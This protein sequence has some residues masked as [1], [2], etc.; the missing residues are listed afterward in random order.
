MHV[1]H[2]TLQF[3][4]IFCGI[5]AG[6]PGLE[7]LHAASVYSRFIHARAVVI[8][9]DRSVLPW[10]AAFVG[11]SCVENFFQLS[12]GRF[13]SR[14]ALA[15][16]RHGCRDGIVRAPGAVGEFVEVVARISLAIEIGDVDAVQGCGFEQDR[17]D[18]SDERTART[19]ITIVVFAGN[20]NSIL[21]R[22]SK[23]YQYFRFD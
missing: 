10:G 4:G 17:K 20:M 3:G 23:Y 16:A 8:A 11:G 14:P 9:D 5:D 1:G 12:F 6:K 19:R 18:E 15:P 22:I 2:D 13:T 7:R 21:R